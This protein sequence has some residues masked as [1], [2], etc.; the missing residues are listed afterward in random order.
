MEPE[1]GLDA[2]GAAGD[3]I[4][5]VDQLLPQV[6]CGRCGYPGCLEYARAVV[7][8]KENINCCA[9]GGDPVAHALSQALERPF[10]SVAAFRSQAMYVDRVARIRE[11]DCIGCTKCIEVCPTSAIVGGRSM[12]HSVLAEDC[13]GCD[14][15][16]P[17][18]PVDCI[19]LIP[20]H[21]PIAP[22]RARQ[23][24]KD[25]DQRRQYFIDNPPA[26]RVLGRESHTHQHA[27]AN[28]AQASAR[29]KG[30]EKIRAAQSKAASRERYAQAASGKDMPT[31]PS[32]KVPQANSPALP[33]AALNPPVV[34]E[35]IQH[36]ATGWRVPPEKDRIR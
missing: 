3:L 27:V 19:D 9:P 11:Q 28:T 26:R 23:K 30:L 36:S 14:L 1:S 22:E 6:Q 18:C 33:K 21:T 13:T 17:P 7:E 5:I 32:S 15:C 10:T 2:N 16:I 29:Q 34:K 31:A 4:E 35:P 25:R 20:V 24:F 8:R 12:S